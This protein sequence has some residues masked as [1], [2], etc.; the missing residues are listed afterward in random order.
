MLTAQELHLAFFPELKAALHLDEFL[1]G[2]GEGYDLPGKLFQDFGG[3]KPHGR[4]E[5][6]ADLAVVTAGVG[7]VGLD[8]RVRVFGDDQRI[9]L[10]DDSDPWPRTR[11]SLETAFDPG[12]G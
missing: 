3:L 7:R 11:L 10:S 6:H 2:N 8:I 9:K 12:Q 1:C 5:H 4:A